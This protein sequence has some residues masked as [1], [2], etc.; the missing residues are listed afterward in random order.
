MIDTHAHYAHRTFDGEFSYVAQG[1]DGL[2]L[3]TGDRSQLFEALRQAGISCSIEPATS[4][5]SNQQVLQL[6]REYPVLPA[7]GLHP[8]RVAEVTGRQLRAL[9]ALART[10]GVAAIGECG[11]DY[12]LP[13]QEQHR[14][15]QLRCF[16]FQIRLAN[17]LELPLILHVRQA[18][19]QVLKVLS[20]CPPRYG[21]VI[22][23]FDQGPDCAA[24]YRKLG[25]Y[26][27]IGGSILAD[28]ALA[29]PLWQAV[30]EM[31]LDR[32]LLE[33]DSPYVKPRCRGSIPKKAMQRA[34]NTSLILP[35]VVH[36][37]AQLKSLPDSTVE[38]ATTRNAERLFQALAASKDPERNSR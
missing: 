29:A 27:G 9:K 20:L 12:H 34:R 18:H 30:R 10:P 11:L 8:T 22:H 1:A 32:I 38:D 13:R 3:Q 2:C 35:A 23:C 7:I 19:S 16:L 5:E 37:I 21:A 26:F 33:T 28:E 36:R 31:P 4:F 15:R 14:L 24:Q 6:S 25:C 17:R